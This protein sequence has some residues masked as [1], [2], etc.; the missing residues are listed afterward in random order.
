MIGFRGNYQIAGS[1]TVCAFDKQV[2]PW[3]SG[4][5]GFGNE[6]LRRVDLNIS[7]T[8]TL[9]GNH[10]VLTST[11]LDK[12]NPLDKCEVTLMQTDLTGE[13]MDSIKSSIEAIAAPSISLFKPL[14][15][16]I[17]CA[18]GAVAAA[19]LCPSARMVF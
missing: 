12:L 2:S 3:V 4:S 16:T 7:S 14:T 15:T 18:S 19:V 13:I 9:L 5:C 17:C 1:K 8:L 10:Q 11:K 6:P